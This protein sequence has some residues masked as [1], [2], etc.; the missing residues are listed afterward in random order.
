MTFALASTG[1]LGTVV[2]AS[3]QSV[4]QEL[5]VS[6]GT[7]VATNPYLESGEQEASVAATAE[8]RPRLIY[9]TSVTR[10]ELQAFARG[11]AFADNYGFGDDYGAAVSVLHRATSQLS[12]SADAGVTS[13][14]S[15]RHSL[16]LQDDEGAVP[17]G[18]VLPELPG[19]DVTVLG[20][21]GR[22]TAISGGVG[23]DYAASA[24][25]TVGVS[26]N[27]QKSF[28]SHA[29]ARDYRVLGANGWY[30]RVVD[31][32]TSIGAVV[33]YSSYDYEDPAAPD[34]E[35]LSVLGS[36]TL[37]LAEAWSLNGTAGV[38]RTRIEDSALADSSTSTSF[39]GNANLCRS[40]S[41]ESFCVAYQR[42]TRPT[43]YAG[44]RNSDSVTVS[45]RLRASERG[46]VSIGGSYSRD[47]GLVSDM[48]IANSR[49]IGVRGGYEHRFNQRF[50]AYVDAA[51]D[52]LYRGGVALDP[53]A[54]VG[55]GIR[56]AFGR[57]G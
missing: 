43:A 27:F 32:R 2:P 13:T 36:F 20:Q 21:R 52:R 23:L 30:Q 48:A 9:D 49:L 4:R 19:D 56:Y 26:G 7:E 40:D 24:R 16:W 57:T 5:V 44:V 12:L 50:S 39:S 53:R 6:L 25:D 35:S 45:Y 41:R 15:P 37:Q 1:L 10:F 31:E 18:P 3:A 11:S 42:G 28:L 55:A 46:A 51:L 17:E 38:E 33:G 22:S 47:S 34:A 29:G 54:R 14:D 8:V